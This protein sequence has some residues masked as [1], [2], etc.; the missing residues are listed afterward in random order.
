M[1]I[2]VYCSSKSNLDNKYTSTAVELGRWIGSNKHELV[3]GGVNAGMMHILAQSAHDAGA[4]ITGIIPECF[5][6]R[7]DELNDTLE[8]TPGLN[9]RKARMYA[10]ADAF[11][12]LPGGWGTLEEATEV[13]TLKQLGLHDKPVVFVNTEEYFEYFF[14]FLHGARREGFISRAYDDLYVVVEEPKDAL[15]YI[16]N[17][18]PRS[19]KDKYV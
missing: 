18:Q 6:S 16:L 13:I 8:T 9:E 4:S 5:T 7:A 12:V 17:Y 11:V 2:T 14:L 3:Y 15:D 1:K 19:R 10:L